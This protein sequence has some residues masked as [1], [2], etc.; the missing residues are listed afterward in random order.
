MFGPATPGEAQAAQ[1]IGGA[2]MAMF[3]AVGLVPALRPYA[4]KIR[5]GVLI[6]YLV[7]GGAFAIY[8]ALH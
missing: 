7:G 3:L 4:W 5:V 2:T 6:A 1:I 8:A